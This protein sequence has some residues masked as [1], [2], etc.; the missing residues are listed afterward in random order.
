[1]VAPLP[2]LAVGLAT[3]V[4]LP[5]QLADHALAD[6]E[7]KRGQLLDEVTLTAA[8]PAQRR[9]GI[10][11]NG[12]LDQFLQRHR[13]PGLPGHRALAA[14]AG[15]AQPGAQFIA[16]APQ[17]RNASL[18]RAARQPG[19]ARGRGDAARALRQRFVGGEQSPGAFIEE[20]RC[21]PPTRADVGDVDHTATL[22]DASRVAPSKFSDSIRALL[23]APRFGYS[24]ASQP[25][26]R[27][28]K[29]DKHRCRHRPDQCEPSDAETPSTVRWSA[30]SASCPN[31]P[32]RRSAIPRSPSARTNSPP[33]D[34]PRCRSW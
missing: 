9:A 23:A 2:R 14:S 11:A 19:C 16:T 10:A 31:T 27:T 21:F 4:Q 5:Q 6:L 29:H 24:D 17:F 26:D 18:D 32:P 30:A 33:A 25:T 13:Q 3:V 15:P 22:A 28:A 7:A 34:W 12:V 1:M 8:D 20:G